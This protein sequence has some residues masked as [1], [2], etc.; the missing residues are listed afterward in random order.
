MSKIYDR[1]ACR[2]LYD[3][4][5]DGLPDVFETAGMKLPTG[6]IISTKIDKPDSDDDGLLDGEEVTYTINNGY[7]KF[8]LVSDPNKIDGDFDGIEDKTDKKAL[9]NYFD[10]N[11]IGTVEKAKYKVSYQMDYSQFFSDNE[12]YNKSISLVSSLFSATIYDGQYI[13][14]YGYLNNSKY[15]FNHFNGI[16]NMMITHGLSDV[17]FHQLKDEY[18]DQHITDV[19][20]GHRNVSFNGTS[21]EIISISIRGTNTST[22][23]WSSNFDVGCYDIFKNNAP[24]SKSDDWVKFENHM[25]FD[26]TANRVKKIIDEYISKNISSNTTIQKTLWITGHS[27]GG[28]IANLLGA[29]YNDDYET[30]VYTFASART[31]TIAKEEAQSYKSIFNIIN[32]DDIIS[33]LPFENWG[34][35]RYG[36]DISRSIDLTYKTSWYEY[37]DKVYN[38]DVIWRKKLVSEMSQLSFGG[39]NG[40]Y[41]YTCGCSHGNG[42]DDSIKMVSLFFF[43]E[44]EYGKPYR[45][46]T[47]NMYVCETV[48]YFMQYLSYLAA[49][50]SDNALIALTD[51]PSKYHSV[52]WSFIRYVLCNNMTYPHLSI[53]YYLL[54][55]KI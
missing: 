32:E 46:I 9:N 23:E 15:D 45:I 26:I 54:S 31:T 5:T 19:A 12:V 29:Y 36:N 53:S 28:A 25:G 22:E 7:V 52:K 14:E 24:I 11:W 35:I 39:R 38:T 40:C 21:K 1:L 43:F 41:A 33:S 27:R 3:S 2:D 34:F 18:E 55:C 49:N 17:E 37:T 16:R 44:L 42:I 10:V 4:D 13:E 51:V 50:G 6:K 20:I 30:F 8:K 48:A 47:R